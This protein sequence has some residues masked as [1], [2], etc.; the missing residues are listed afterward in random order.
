MV[1]LGSFAIKKPKSW[2]LDQLKG[3]AM[4]AGGPIGQGVI[5]ALELSENKPLA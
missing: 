5:S 1:T 3:H 4:R 2:S